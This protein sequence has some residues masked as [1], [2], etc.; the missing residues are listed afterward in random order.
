[1]RAIETNQRPASESLLSD[2]AKRLGKFRD[3]RRAVH[4]HLSRLKPYN[5]RKHH[6]RIVTSVLDP[7][8]KRFDGALFHLYNNDIIIICKDVAVSD[9]DDNV[10]RLRFLFSEDPLLFGTEQAGKE[11]CSWYDFSEDYPRFKTLTDEVLTAYERFEAERTAVARNRVANGMSADPQIVT[12]I[13]APRLGAIENAI[14]RADLSHLIHRQAI[15]TFTKGSPPRPLLYEIY[16]SIDELREVLLPSCDLT[17]N[18]WLFLDLTRHLDRRMMSLLTWSNDSSLRESISIN[19]NIS[20]VLSPEF[21]ELDTALGTQAAN[22]FVIEIQLIDALADVSSFGFARDFL[23]DRGYRVCL[24]GV[25][26]RSLPFVDRGELGVDL[27]KLIWSGDLLHYSGSRREDFSRGVEKL[28]P[29]RVILC[30]CDSKE[31]LDIGRDLGI[32]LYQGRMVDQRLTESKASKRAA[33][34]ETVFGHGARN[35]KDALL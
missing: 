4:F 33:S 10:R 17:A 15:C 2:Y 26:H 29:E 8:V 18:P 21:L 24:D 13:D 34:L 16:I 12:A 5:R 19:L 22:S 28:S 32:A 14:A 25:T 6:L 1:M 31:A 3:G 23:H 20:T 27:V 35:R 11:F 30:R 9:I 7:M